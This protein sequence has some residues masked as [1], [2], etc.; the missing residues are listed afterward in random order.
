MG[1]LLEDIGTH[2]EDTPPQPAPRE[3]PPVEEP[4]LGQE[5][6]SLM[7]CGEDDEE[8]DPLKRTS[9]F[10]RSSSFARSGS[11]SGQRGALVPVAAQP[12]SQP[13]GDVMNQLAGIS[14]S[15]GGGP[16]P[17]LPP[18]SMQQQQPV[19]QSQLSMSELLNP[20]H[21]VPNGGSPAASTTTSQ[22]VQ[23]GVA[24]VAMP[25]TTGAGAG[26]QPVAY[27]HPTP[28][29]VPGSMVVNQQG[30]PVMYP[31]HA[32]GVI[33]MNQAGMMGKLGGDARPVQRP[34]P[35][36]ELSPG[37]ESGFGFLGKSNKGA[38]FDFVQDEMT[39]MK[40]K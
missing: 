9:S 39:Q 40:N 2:V 5:D 33:Y 29:M 17:V 25:M 24:M 6:D 31:A 18:D 12:Q 22:F 1:V 21:S 32:P 13:S 36:R 19:L 14:L 8:F 27:P 26:V 4:S 34:P 28:Y 38:A 23:G 20:M 30:V 37:P 35:T 15:S 3:E 10:T 16:V 11:L 7:D